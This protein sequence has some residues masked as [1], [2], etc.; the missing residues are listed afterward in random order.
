MLQMELPHAARWEQLAPAQTSGGRAPFKSAETFGLE[1]Q[2]AEKA[3]QAEQGV[4][5]DGDGAKR[6]EAARKA[7]LEIESA[8]LADRETEEVK[9]RAPAP[10]VMGTVVHWSGRGFGILRSQA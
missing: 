5:G 6:L 1:F 8:M 10:L 3:M 2:Q 7:A 4:E 9:P